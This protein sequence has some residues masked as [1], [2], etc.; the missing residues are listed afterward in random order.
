MLLA[1]DVGNTNMVFGMYEGEVLTGSFRLMT[2]SNRT[3]DEIGLSAWE[4]FQ[5]FGLRTEDVE[6][7]IIAS[8]VPQIMHTLTNAM[9]KYF[10]KTPIIV[11]DDVDPGLPYGVSG[12]EHLGADRSVACVSAIQKYGKPLVVLDFG[13]ATT[14]DAVSRDGLYLGGCITAGVRISTDALFQKAA[15]LP[16]VELVKPDT[17]LGCTAVGQIQAGAVLGYIGAMEY[18]IRLTKEEMGEPKAKVVATGG[19]ARMIADNTDVIDIVDS[20]LILDG[21]RIIHN[22]CKQGK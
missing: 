17:V 21:L 1:I 16:K 4:Y 5:R 11:D 3:S 8:V 19:L 22:R 7:V 20:Q 13:T 12:D 15:M 6:D 18:L 9:I 10:D 2:D 14:I